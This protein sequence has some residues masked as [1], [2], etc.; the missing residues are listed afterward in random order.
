V[1]VQVTAAD[2]ER[3]VAGDDCKCP[4]ALAIRRATGIPTSV[5]DG[6]IVIDYATPQQV[7]IWSPEDV[8]HFVEEFDLGHDVEPFEFELEYPTEDG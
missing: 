7:E 1:K 4:V 6:V 3:G 5:G 8:A 2:I